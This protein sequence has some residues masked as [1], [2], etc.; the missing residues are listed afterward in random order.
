MS[1]KSTAQRIVEGIAVVLAIGCLVPIGLV[2]WGRFFKVTPLSQQKAVIDTAMVASA[3]PPDLGAPKRDPVDSV[4]MLPKKYP[5][6]DDLNVHRPTESNDA[7]A[8]LRQTTQLRHLMAYIGNGVYLSPDARRAVVFETTPANT[9]R[10]AIW[11]VDAGKLIRF[12]SSEEGQGTR[13]YRGEENANFGAKV[14]HDQFHWGSFSPDGKKF[15]AHQGIG[16]TNSARRIYM[17][18]V[19]T[20]KLLWQLVEPAEFSAV[21]FPSPDFL[22]IG[23]AVSMRQYAWRR[24]KADT[25]DSQLL[26]AVSSTIGA[27][28]DA[29]GHAGQVAYLAQGKLVSL[30]VASRAA[31]S[32]AHDTDGLGR[33]SGSHLWYSADGKRVY[34]LSSQ[35]ERRWFDVWDAATH[36]L[37][38]TIEVAEN[39]NPSAQVHPAPHA[40]LV[41]NLASGGIGFF[42]LATGK[43]AFLIQLSFHITPHVSVS[44]DARRLLV[45]TDQQ[46]LVLIDFTGELPQGRVH[47]ASL[48]PAGEL[49][50]SR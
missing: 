20:G 45:Q 5:T 44:S 18:E 35:D 38:N 1:S 41:A 27:T 24:I 43:E 48:L 33:R 7:V 3:T 47:L 17:W 8:A 14:D 4:E 36:K 40:N 50:A 12:F 11:N 31:R 21:L 32:P 16:G 22:V 10:V 39:A 23:S 29:A 6:V 15:A 13:E 2:V 28:T 26:T 34:R 9:T 30:D 19:D 42:N 37:V 46:S 25:G 49:P